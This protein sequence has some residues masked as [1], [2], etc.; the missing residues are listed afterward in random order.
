[1][2]R[3]LPIERWDPDRMDFDVLAGL[4]EKIQLIL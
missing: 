4:T 1:M 2:A 3:A